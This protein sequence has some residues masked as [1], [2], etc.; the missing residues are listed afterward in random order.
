MVRMR[1]TAPL[2]SIQLRL[3]HHSYPRIQVNVTSGCSC[4]KIRNAFHTGGSAIVLTIVAITPM[5][6]AVVFLNHLASQA[7]LCP[8]QMS[9]LISAGTFSISASTGNALKLPG[10]VMAQK[11]APAEKTNFTAAICSLGMWCFC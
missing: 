6:P 11:I 3:Y 4:A 7:R 8:Q 5:R 10:C 2:L 1:R 9:I